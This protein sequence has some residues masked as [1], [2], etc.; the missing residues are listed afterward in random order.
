MKV[1][2]LFTALLLSAGCASIVGSHGTEKLILEV[3]GYRLWNEVYYYTGRTETQWLMICKTLSPEK[4]SMKDTDIIVTPKDV[5]YRCPT[6][7]IM[8]CEV[9]RGAIASWEKIAKKNA[10]TIDLPALVAKAEELA[11]KATAIE[12]RAGGSGSDVYAAD[13]DASVARQ[14][15]NRAGDQV[16]QAELF[17]NALVISAS[18]VVRFEVTKESSND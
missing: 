8:R 16:G 3:V 7:T 11:R 5:L 13:S 9:E 17:V 12:R 4:R 15:A 2:V 10:A 18:D 14:E 1:F 6:G